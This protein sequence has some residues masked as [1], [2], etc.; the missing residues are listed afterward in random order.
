M[1]SAGIDST[2]HSMSE[3]FLKG[4]DANSAMQDYDPTLGTRMDTGN[5]NLTMQKY[6]AHGQ[7]V[8]DTIDQ[9]EQEKKLV[10]KNPE[11]KSRV[12]AR[13]QK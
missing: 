7:K 1:K 13:D 10:D 2:L 4:G 11:F 6:L 8:I 9:K 5:K 3:L 12:S